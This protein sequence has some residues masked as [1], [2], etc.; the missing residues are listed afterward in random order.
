[1]KLM[2]NYIYV[3]KNRATIALVDYKTSNLYGPRLF[4]FNQQVSKDI[5]KYIEDNKLFAK[6]NR[7]GTLFGPSPM[8]SWVKKLLDGL[9]LPTGAGREG[10]INYLRKSYV[11]SELDEAGEMSADA[12]VQLAFHKRH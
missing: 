10:N 12:R 3:S 5:W 7:S 1:M 4:E 6:A 8:R 2:N 9:G 11:S